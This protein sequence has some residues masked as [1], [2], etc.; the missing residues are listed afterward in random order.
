MRRV[1][2]PSSTAG[3]V[4]LTFTCAAVAVGIARLEDA[5]LGRAL[6]AA[7]PA[8]LC[9]AFGLR[10]AEAPRRV[11]SAM[12][13]TLIFASVVVVPSVVSD[14]LPPAG[15]PAVGG[16]L[17]EWIVTAAVLVLVA[18]FF[19]WQRPTPSEGSRRGRDA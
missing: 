13:G 5:E 14:S 1:E 7:P 18:F 2:P 19:G 11:A 3:A 15:L 8:A 10:L 12:G 9:A 17:G 4:L 16:R 6:V